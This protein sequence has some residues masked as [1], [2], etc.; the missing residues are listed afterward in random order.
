MFKQI[1]IDGK[2]LLVLDFKKSKEFTDTY[3]VSSSACPNPF[4]PCEWLKLEFENKSK[5][6]LIT[7][8]FDIERR[9]I[10]DEVKSSKSRSFHKQIKKELSPADWEFLN[11]NLQYVKVVYTQNFDLENCDNEDIPGFNDVK[12]ENGALQGYPDYYIWDKKISFDIDDINYYIF[13]QYCLK[14]NCD[15]REVA[16]QFFG[17]KNFKNVFK[18]NK[19]PVISYRYKRNTWGIEGE[20][21]RLPHDYDVL[22]NSLKKEYPDISNTFKERHRKLKLLYAKYLQQN[23]FQTINQNSK[24][25]VGR[26]EP[27]PCGSGKK[28]KKCCG[29]QN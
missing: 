19:N 20:I 14:S 23:K 28:Y 18:T 27:C 29:T 13:D 5:N 10:L 15:C 12:I 6:E 1:E 24:Q 8:E 7:L 17:I 25:K 22:V 4:C 16:V 26:N 2:I 9:K 11:L 3:E 21:S